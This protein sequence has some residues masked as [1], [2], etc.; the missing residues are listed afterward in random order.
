MR[1][2]NTCFILLVIFTLAGSALLTNCE[3]VPLK[4]PVTPLIT[5]TSSTDLNYAA[6]F[7]LK[8]I[9]GK[10]V[11]LEDYKN[12][13]VLLLFW[14]TGSSQ[15][16]RILPDIVKL[17]AKYKEKDF[18][19][20]GIITERP[21]SGVLNTV[22]KMKEVYGIGF[23]LVWYDNKVINDYG[24]IEKLPRSFF[25]NFEKKIAKDIEGAGQYS[26]YETALLEILN[27]QIIK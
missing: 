12:K 25:I 27:A 13:I 5:D 3:E 11:K 6:D 8:S 21:E 15:C 1:I 26:D 14:E 20:I 9:D 10:V 2:H 22:K 23:P 4:S 7:T 18:E 16:R 24:P 19:I 17:H